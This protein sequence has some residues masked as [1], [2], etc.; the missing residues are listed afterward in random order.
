MSDLQRIG[1]GLDAVLRRL[2]LP[3]ADALQRL[4]ED[5]RSLAGEPWASRSRPAGLRRGELTVEV[6]DGATASLLKYQSAELLRR[7]EQGLGGPLVEAVRL[8]VGSRKKGS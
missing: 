8:R 7:L 2:G 6:E 1:E 3:A 4:V 5:W